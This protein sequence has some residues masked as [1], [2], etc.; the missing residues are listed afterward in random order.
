MDSLGLEITLLSDTTFGRGDGVAGVVD[1]EVE[2]DA[3]TGLPIIK[4]RTLK[5]LLVEECSNILYALLVSSSPAYAAMNTAAERLFG[6]PGSNLHGQSILHI[7]TA[8]LPRSLADHLRLEIAY[9]RLTPQA[10]LEALTTIRRQTAVDSERDVPKDNTLRAMRVILRDTVFE[11]PVLLRETP[12]DDELSLLA[13]CAASLRRA[14][15]SRN[16]G[17]GRIAVRV[18]GLP[19]GALDWFGQRVKGGE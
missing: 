9:G 16:R 12:T 15:H 11:A 7:G 1:Q 2:H 6:V 8:T 4:G 3:A 5:G 19:D 13:A 17:R 18:K 10:V 14:G